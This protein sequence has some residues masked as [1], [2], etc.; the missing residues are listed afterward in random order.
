MRRRN[1]LATVGLATSLGF[2]G[3]SGDTG[4]N[5]SS[6]GGGGGNGGGGDGGETE[7]S[8]GDGGGDATEASGEDGEAAET[9]AASGE[10][11]EDGEATAASGE[12]DDE[13]STSGS[14]GDSDDGDDSGSDGGSGGSG[15]ITDSGETDIELQ[16]AQVDDAFSL[17]SA[18]FYNEDD[19]FSVGVRGEV[20][21]TSDSAVDYMEVNALFYDSEG[22]RL[23]DGLDNL[24][25][26][27]AGETYKYDALYLGSNDASEIASYSLE[28]KN[29]L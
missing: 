25:D 8:G 5:N 1:Y 22:S 19:G 3:C 10:S 2:A 21:N 28:V 6:G 23:G 18:E 16:E 26:F 15:S 4:G 7:A 29:G 11:G 27:Q 14:E 13:E 24:N 9:T 17:D 12:S 20:T